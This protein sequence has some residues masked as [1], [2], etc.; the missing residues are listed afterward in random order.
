M[1]TLDVPLGERSYPIHIG[2]GLL[3]RGELLLSSIRGRDV[4]VVTN[5]TVAPLYLAR[6]EAALVQNGKS[7]LPVIL[8]DGE[9]YKN[10]ET[11]NRIFDALLANNCER[12]TTLIA[13]GGGVIGDMGGFA[14]ACYQRGMPFVQIPTTLLAQVDSS[15]GGKTAINHPLGKNMIGAFYQP[16]VVVADVA[17]LET[18]PDRELKAGLAE[19]VKYG[20]IRDL[21]FLDWI[22]KNARPLLRR[23]R[24]ALIFAI[25]RSCRNK[26]EV[27]AAD[28]REAG[29]RALLNLGHTFGH[30][31]EAGLG[32]GA[33]LHGEAVAAGT[34]IAAE[35]SELVGWLSQEDVLRVRGLFELLGLPTVAPRLGVARYM[36]L[37]RHDKKV[38]DGQLRLVLLQKLGQAV[39]TD[40]ASD[41]QI[42][43]AIERGCT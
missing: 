2:A 10:W 18:L 8:P 25:E 27:V 3:D 33:W 14:A 23:D 21:P 34:M 43:C 15:V 36:E 29:E 5:E 12:N 37:M 6:L 7:L 11:L 1:Y 26:A 4:V 24:D 38:L 22:E 28:E 41:E 16:Q 9:A 31:I 19:V 30:A 40:G 32:Y 13:L 20:L 39:L 35:L 17:T 42:S